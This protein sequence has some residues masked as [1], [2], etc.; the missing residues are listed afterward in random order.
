MMSYHGFRKGNMGIAIST[1]DV[2]GEV[3]TKKI[4]A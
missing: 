2:S 3:G 1:V 4:P